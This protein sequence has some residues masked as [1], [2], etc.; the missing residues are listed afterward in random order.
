[1][2]NDFRPELGGADAQ[3]FQ[4]AS[5]PDLAFDS[6]PLNGTARYRL[7][8]ARLKAPLPTSLSDVAKLRP[9]CSLAYQQRLLA[10]CKEFAAVTGC[11]DFAMIGLE[12]AMA[13]LQATCERQ[14]SISTLMLN[15]A[16]L[17]R[18]WRA[19]KADAHNPFVMVM[20]V[21]VEQRELL[22]QY[23]T[24]GRAGRVWQLLNCEDFVAMKTSSVVGQRAAY[25][26]GLL[27][28]F[29]DMKATELVHLR[30]DDFPL[31]TCAG[32][33]FRRPTS[34][35]GSGRLQSVHSVL[36]RCGLAEFIAE[37]RATK[38]AYLLSDSTE[39]EPSPRAACRYIAKAW[40]AA[41]YATPA[42]S[43][44]DFRVARRSEAAKV[45]A[46]HQGL[47]SRVEA[48]RRQS[49]VP[50]DEMQLVLDLERAIEFG[51]VDWVHHYNA[52]SI[53]FDG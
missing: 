40:E 4:D 49:P 19:S 32:Q 21:L 45:L 9:G 46:E 16:S 42:P 41:G 39:L 5:S 53:R 26:T 3:S 36:V 22:T 8:R 11:H 12:H 48:S 6:A 15:M 35:W 29:T 30:P 1:M 25:W 20:S 24:E 43:W 7:R 23:E 47:R 18:L 38:A 50:V 13:Y 33:L 52:Q 51:E 27:A 37:R 31:T 44:H 14:R 28:L 34:R 10:L 2:L 17:E